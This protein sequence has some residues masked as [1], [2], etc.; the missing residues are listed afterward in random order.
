M[1][2][3]LEKDEEFGTHPVDF[4]LSVPGTRDRWLAV[5]F[6]TLG[7]GDSD[8]QVAAL[9]TS[10]RWHGD[11]IP[12]GAGSAGVSSMR[13]GRGRAGQPDLNEDPADETVTSELGWARV[14][15]DMRRWIPLPLAFP[16][17]HDR[18]SWAATAAAA[19]SEQ[20]ELPADSAEIERLATM[21]RL[22]HERANVRVKCHQIWIYLPDRF[23]APLPVFIAIWRQSGERDRRL[24]LLAGA[25][26]KSGA[27][28]PQMA[29]VTTEHLGTGLRVLRHRAPDKGQL[30]AL[31]GYAFRVEEH[32]TDLQVFTVTSDLRAL[33]TASDDIERLVQ[34]ILT[35]WYLNWVQDTY[36]LWVL[37]LIGLMLP[38]MYVGDFVFGHPIVRHGYGPTQLVRPR[39]TR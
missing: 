31:L 7:D 8:D 11:D 22:I 36:P 32:K 10:L 16:D 28:K 25:D 6:S 3:P 4:V 30:L 37:R 21:I 34:G 19:W 13:L 17:G 29:E 1:L 39:P 9:L 20:W 2:T 12:L 33:T 35:I 24:R 15:V 18:D 26:D 14:D 5:C 38:A 23:T 27:H